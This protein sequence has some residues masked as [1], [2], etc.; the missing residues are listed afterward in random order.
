MTTETSTWDGPSGP[1][2]PFPNPISYAG[3]FTMDAGVMTS[4]DIG[5]NVPSFQFPMFQPGA[6]SIDPVFITGW[7]QYDEVHNI[8]TGVLINGIDDILLLY[9]DQTWMVSLSG[10]EVNESGVYSVSGVPEPSAWSLLGA[11]VLV[12]LIRGYGA[13][14]GPGA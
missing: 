4:F 2:S 12:T 14:R 3:E 11:I 10:G 7:V 8:L 5:E 13:K 9:S 6:L 1:N